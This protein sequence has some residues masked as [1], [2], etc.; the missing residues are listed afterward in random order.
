[1][2]DSTPVDPSNAEYFR[3]GGPV[4]RFVVSLCIYDFEEPA[5]LE[6][7]LG[8]VP[9]SSHRA[10]DRHGPADRAIWQHSAW[11]LTRRGKAPQQVEDAVF[12]LLE[13]IDRLALAQ[14]S[15]RA[16]CKLSLGLFLR[17]ADSGFWLSNATMANVA[18]AGLTLDCEVFVD[19][20]A[21]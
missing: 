18:A 4:D 10:G 8:V 13:S 2:P 5:E 1:M 7:L 15:S 16:D 12:S 3:V 20:R 21:Q 19:T 14:I 9:T 17:S 11:I 6:R